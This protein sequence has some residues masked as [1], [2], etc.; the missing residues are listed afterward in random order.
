M[1]FFNKL[2]NNQKKE[3]KISSTYLTK[4]KYELSDSILLNVHPDILNY[5]WV[6]DGKMKN[7]TPQRNTGKKVII[8]DQLV[9]SRHTK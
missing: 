6:G 1:G 9:S 7:Y 4:Q 3:S 2:F 5:I 8:N